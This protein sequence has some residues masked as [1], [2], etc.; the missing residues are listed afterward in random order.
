MILRA[1]RDAFLKRAP[2]MA[3]QRFRV[4]GCDRK[5]ALLHT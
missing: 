5:K 4:L 3:D 1:Q 2:L